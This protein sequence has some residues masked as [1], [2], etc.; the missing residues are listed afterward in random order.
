M[1]EKLKRNQYNRY[2]IYLVFFGALF[3]FFALAMPIDS[4]LHYW[5]AD[6][7]YYHLALARNI[8][9]GN[10]IVFNS[11]IPTNGFHP[12][13]VLI[14]LP[15]FSILYP[16]GVSYP[17]YGALTMLS[18]FDLGTAIFIYLICRELLNE[19]AGLIGCGVWLF[20]P[21]ILITGLQGV[22]PP[23]QVFLISV[24]TWYLVRKPDISDLSYSQYSFIGLMLGLIFLARM[25]GI[26][27]AS[28]IILSLIIN[29][30]QNIGKFKEL[31]SR[32][33]Y[34]LIPGAI[35]SAT[36]LA[37]MTWSFLH[38]G[39]FT[40]V[41]GAAT[42][43]LRLENNSYL[44]RATRSIMISGWYLKNFLLY[45]DTNMIK[46][47]LLQTGLAV[48]TLA[49]F[50]AYTLWKRRGFA[51]R[52]LK[53]LDFLICTVIL[54]HLFYWF[55]A[56]GIRPWYTHFPS[57]VVAL[58]F[59]LAATKALETIDSQKKRKTAYLGLIGLIGFFFV[60]GS[61][62]FQQPVSPQEKTKKQAADYID[63][64]IPEN[65]TLGSSNTGI[66]QYFTPRHEV[67]NLD[68]V[69]N[70]EA[71]RARKKGD[72]SGYIIRKDIS[73][74]VDTEG[75]MKKVTDRRITVE[76]IKS[77]ERPSGRHYHLYRLYY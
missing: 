44:S 58:F 32:P 36:V 11:G 4:I 16:L 70:P 20:N 47:G 63:K 69:M 12:L 65:A 50:P 8:I 39:R 41:S 52:V 45:Q 71:Y 42:R 72:I 17:V 10:S 15:F 66:Y 53:K 43:M 33:G 75:A 26:F 19:K 18:V 74:L 3:R 40:P 62:I 7:M 56:V 60:L 27:L 38:T 57:F 22:E 59:P 54:F 34:L 49:S 64:N 51:A 76:K 13:I 23:I 46:Q 2:L 6:D 24:L 21:L 67:I 14:F 55:Y 30:Y 37:Y 28:S 9:S 31:I 1:L 35:F 73:Y 5:T 68:G 29:R 25:D 77:F 48:F 61:P